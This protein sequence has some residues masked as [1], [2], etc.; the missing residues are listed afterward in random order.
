MRSEISDLVSTFTIQLTQ[1]IL[2]A[3]RSVLPGIQSEVSA[4]TP[5]KAAK[6]DVVASLGRMKKTGR[7]KQL[8]PVPGCTGLAAPIFGMVCGEHRK[9]AKSR[10]AKYRAARKAMTKRGFS[11]DGALASFMETMGYRVGKRLASGGSLTDDLSPLFG[12]TL[13]DK[14]YSRY[15]MKS[16]KP[17]AKVFC[18]VPGCKGVAAPIFGMVCGEHKDV[19]KSKIAK[20]RKDRKAGKVTSPAKV[21]KTKTVAQKATK[22]ATKKPITTAAKPASQKTI[23]K[24]TKPATKKPI[25]TVAKPASKK[26]IKKSI[27]TAAK[28]ASKKTIKKATKPATKKPITTAAMTDANSEVELMAKTAT[29]PAMS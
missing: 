3:I 17:R 22:P 2:S 29:M 28:P 24:A 21:V 11:R 18:P 14:P 19:A 5:F 12:G 1:R 7:P 13:A 20:Y 27:T 25:T 16:R 23:K 4:W 9:V 26:T 6:P 15:M 8:C 10:I